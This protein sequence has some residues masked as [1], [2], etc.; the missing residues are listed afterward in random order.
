MD[1]SSPA[2]DIP[3]HTLDQ[4]IRWA[5]VLGSGQVS[6][7]DRRA[8]DQWLAVSPENARAWE[9]VQIIEGEFVAARPAARS[10]HRAL[11]RLA[12]GRRHRRLTLGAGGLLS[13][14][15]LV[16]LS[17]QLLPF[18][19][20]W[21]P[22][23][24]TATAERRSIALEGG[25]RLHLNSRSALDIRRGAEGLVLELHRGELLVDSS[26]AA[27]AD[28][29]RVV[30]TEGRFR[31]LGTRFVV[32][33]RGQSSE[34]A[35]LEGKVA[36]NAPG[37]AAQISAAGERWRLTGNDIHQLPES[38]L[39]PGAWAEGLLQADN[40][41][42]GDLLEALNRHRRGWLLYDQ[43]VAELRVTGVFRLDDT[44]SALTALENSLPV[45]VERRLHWWVKV[46]PKKSAK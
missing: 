17:L 31:P 36:L 9:R 16:G 18:Q 5:V 15:L 42:L 32:R 7:S 19:L 13:L 30:T 14:L 35:V 38:G 2:Q 45:R 26:A 6:D 8:F 3:E 11:R 25:T 1:D 39:E 20:P 33:K 23:Y 22:Q 44:D 12:Q 37:Q 21:Q 28:K 40:A 34:L 24:L 4:A 10:G 41:R 43:Q 27:P 29:P 46:R